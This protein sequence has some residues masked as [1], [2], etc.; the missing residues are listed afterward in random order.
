MEMKLWSHQEYARE[1]TAALD[2]PGK[3]IIVASPTGGGKTLMMQM[4]LERAREHY[5][6]AVYYS[7][8][9][10]LL[11]QTSR[12]WESQ[13][14]DHGIRMSGHEP[15]LAEEVQLSS[16]QTERSRVYKQGRWN[17]HDANVF[18]VDEGHLHTTGVSSQ[19]IQDHKESGAFGIAYTA[20]PLEMNHLH[21]ELVVAGKNSELRE[22]GAHLP[23]YVYGCGEMDTSKIERVATGEFSINQI[24]KKVW[25]QKIFGHVVNHHRRLNPDMRPAIG[26]APGVQESIWLAEQYTRAGITAAHIDGDDVWA[27]GEFHKSNQAARDYVIERWER[28]DIKICWN[29]F[30]MREG[31]DFPWLYHLILATPIGSLTSYIQ[32]VGRVLRYWPDYDHVI[33]QDHG[34]NWWRHGSPNEDCDWHSLWKLK[35]KTITDM[36]LDRIREGE[37]PQPIECP[38]CGQLRIAGPACPGCGFKYEKR[39]RLVLQANGELKPLVPG[40]LRRRRRIRQEGDREE[41][42]RYYYRGR[43]S[44]MTFKQIE[45]LWAIEHDWRWPTRDLP[46]MPRSTSDWFR[47]VKDVPKESLI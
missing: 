32:T 37:D 44:N 35:N 7:N 34:G 22:C 26:F 31:L 9:R 10:W 23:C 14:I 11:E 25:S 28:G 6:R 2:A 13:G 18:I 5:K 4:E 36:R 1:K 15:R 21:D 33:V 46:L 40:E 45:G 24:R 17:L 30:V 19:I 47:K 8:R 16:V 43:N 29:R 12:K 42:K 20:T 27:D 39:M 38:E 41:W 3:S